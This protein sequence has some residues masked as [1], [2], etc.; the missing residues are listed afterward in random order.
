MSG[1]AC[2]AVT[3]PELYLTEASWP[4]LAS[5]PKHRLRRPR[6]HPHVIVPL[7]VSVN[8]YASPFGPRQLGSLLQSR[9]DSGEWQ[10]L[11]AA[12][13]WVKRSGARH[14]DGSL[15]RFSASGGIAKIAVGIDSGGSTVEGLDMLA[16]AIATVGELWIVH[17]SNPTTTFHPKAFLFENERAAVALIGSG[18][19][20]EGGLFTN[21]ELGAEL[22]FDLRKPDDVG[23]ADSIRSELCRYQVA[24]LIS[25]QYSPQLREQLLERGDVVTEAQ[26]GEKLN[27]AIRRVVSERR[28]P[29]FG[30]VPIPPAP[31]PQVVVAAPTRRRKPASARHSGPATA[32]PSSAPRGFVMSL[33]QTDAGVG[34]RTKGASRR[35]PELFVPLAA[36][37]AN[38]DFWGWPDRFVEDTRRNGKFDRVQVAVRL[39]DETV[40][41]NMMTWPI[42]HDFRLRSEQLRSAGRVGDLLR[43]ERAESGASFDYYAEIVR[44]GT[45]MHSSYLAICTE[46]VR[47]SKKRWGYYL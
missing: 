47:N 38:P 28:P 15:R 18:N 1:E 24:G 11:T 31:R 37:D 39:E 14:L 17:H 25:Q 44:S 23:V 19:L 3:P 21:F 46:V 10:H 36:R 22:T 9:L 12:I 32:E 6:R 45:V 16:D 30:S 34:Q 35:S 29:V 27:E 33:Q 7:M 42:K 20:T 26:A 8:Y 40:L 13:A 4:N 43:L 41:V 5:L 2:L